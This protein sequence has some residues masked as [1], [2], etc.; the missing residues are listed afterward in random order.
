M[1]CRF[2]QKLAGRLIATLLFAWLAVPAYSA[3]GVEV[4]RVHIEPTDDGYVLSANFGFELNHGLEEA[5]THGIPLNFTIEVELTRPRWY[6]FSEKAISATQTVRIAY[7]VLTR[8][9][10]V[11]AGGN[12]EQRFSTLD[13]ALAL[14]RRPTRWVV[15][16]KARLKF[17]ETYDGTV[18]LRLDLT[19]LPKPFQVNSLNNSDWRFSS[20]WKHFT[21]RV[22]E[23]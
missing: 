15:A 8:Q 2:L 14:I 1:I 4:T 19:Q 23:K 17:G 13:D 3:D 16:D 11:S 12:M 5:I 6:W 10:R 9:Y 7:N 22:D 20:D 21:Y 18:Q